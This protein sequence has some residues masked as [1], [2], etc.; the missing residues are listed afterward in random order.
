M[1]TPSDQPIQI[2]LPDTVRLPSG[3]ARTFQIGLGVG[4]VIGLAGSIYSYLS[5]PQQFAFSYITA[6]MFVT[7]LGLGGLFWTLI[8][9]LSGA[10]WSVVIRRFAENTSWILIA[11]PV[12]FLPFLLFDTQAYAWMTESPENDPLLAKKLPYLTKGF[13]YARA[14]FYFAVWAGISFFLNRYSRRQ[15]AD[16]APQHSRTVRKWSGPCMIALALTSSFAAFDFMMSLDYHWFSTIFGVY[17]WAGSIWA[18]MAAMILMS[19]GFRA[20]GWLRN[21]VTIEHLH[22]MGKLLFGFTMFWTYIAFSQFFLIWYS[23]IPEETLWYIHRR[24]GAEELPLSWN[25]LSWALFFGHF[26]IPF[27]FLLRRQVKRTPVLLSLAAVWILAFHYLDLYWEIMPN[28]PAYAGERGFMFQLSDL[29]TLL[30]LV[31]ASGLVI[32]FKMVGDPLI[33]LRDPRLHESLAFQNS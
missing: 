25:N 22:D 24:T 18:T 29:S 4:L 32:C 26:L 12:F 30:T 10:G 7:S 33:P 5:D 16:G 28:N 11:L 1:S 9:H 31:C 14:I 20:A 17:Y 2:Q 23:N 21:T 19:T 15:D 3:S 6:F 8:H 27:F 13:F